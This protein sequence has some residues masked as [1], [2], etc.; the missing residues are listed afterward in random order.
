MN[1]CNINATCVRENVTDIH[2]AQ[3]VLTHEANRCN[4]HQVHSTTR[5]IPSYR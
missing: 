5:E 4:H 3:R 2:H 1:D